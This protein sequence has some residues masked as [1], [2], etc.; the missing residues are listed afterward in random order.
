MTSYGCANL[1][2]GQ[3]ARGLSRPSCFMR[4]VM[5]T[6]GDVFTTTGRTVLRY[7]IMIRVHELR[8]YLVIY[9][10]NRLALWEEQLRK[11]DASSIHEKTAVLIP[12]EDDLSESQKLQFFSKFL[13]TDAKA[14]SRSTK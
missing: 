6:G 9:R 7:L 2:W 5:L 4:G 13:N 1:N 12:V 8:A 14:E 10:P 3:P 11:L